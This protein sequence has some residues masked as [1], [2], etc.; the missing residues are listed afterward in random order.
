M[1]ND[2]YIEHISRQMEAV[3]FILQIIS[4]HSFENWGILLGLFNYVMHLG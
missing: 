4:R 3:V 1:S 2:K